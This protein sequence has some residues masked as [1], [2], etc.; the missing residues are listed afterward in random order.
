MDVGLILK[1]NSLDI[2]KE[3]LTNEVLDYLN[4]FEKITYS[5]IK[6]AY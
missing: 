2:D 5:T 4:S 1:E 3:K 6:F